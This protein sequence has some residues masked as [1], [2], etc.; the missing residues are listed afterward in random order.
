MTERPPWLQTGVRGSGSRMLK[1][2]LLMGLL[3]PSCV[4]LAGCTATQNLGG[5]LAS[6]V[7]H[8]SDAS[9]GSSGNASAGSSGNASA[10]SSGNA[11]AGSSGNASAGSSG[12]GQGDRTGVASGGSSGV[13]GSAAGTPSGSR[14][15]VSAGAGTGTPS[16]GGASGVEGGASAV[17]GGVSGGPEAGSGSGSGAG[18]SDE[19]DAT[20]DANMSEGAPGKAA[21]E[22]GGAVVG[23][24][25]STCPSGTSMDSDGRCLPSNDPYLG[26]ANP[27]FANPMANRLPGCSTPNATPAC[28]AQGNCVI[29]SCHPGFADC[30]GNPTDGCEAD[31]TSPGT[32]GSCTTACGGTQVCTPSGCASSCPLGLTSCNG[33]CADLSSS[34]LH[35]GGCG[36][37]CPP[38]DSFG[39]PSCQGGECGLVCEP[40]YTNCD[41]IC[42]DTHRDP[43]ACGSCTACPPIQN[44]I[45]TCSSGACASQCPFGWTD[46]GTACAV[47][48]ADPSNCG[49][50]GFACP[51]GNACQ[52]GQ[53]APVSSLMLATASAPEGITVDGNNV[54]FT[55]PGNGTV[56]A[57]SMDG[58]AVTTLATNQQKPRRLVGD[59]TYLYWSN[60]LG[61]E[62]MR[63]LE[64]GAGT[65]SVLTAASEPLGIA[66]DATNVYWIDAGTGLVKAVAKGGGSS[67]TLIGANG[68]QPSGELILASGAL[69][70]DEM[71]NIPIGFRLPSGPFV[72]LSTMQ[73]D[74]QAYDFSAGGSYLYWASFGEYAWYNL[75]NG[76][77][78]LSYVAAVAS[79][80]SDP[81][82]G[83]DSCGAYTW[84][85]VSQNQAE[86]PGVWMLA[87]TSD[88]PYATLAPVAIGVSADGTPRLATGGAYVFWANPGGSAGSVAG[89]YRALKPQ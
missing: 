86:I 9:A 63:T 38:G 14:A 74:V 22:A 36:G 29:A 61:G 45:L 50:C 15:G 54:F 26:C 67:V 53:C 56:N 32:C 85:E 17:E 41:G 23:T 52:A 8:A 89:V 16:E 24:L 49:A 64:S 69:Y 60:Y 47:L 57:V 35:C 31:L 42:F 19:G 21:A 73:E 83:A 4:A 20:A 5:D 81:T 39:A 27:T 37:I 77:L 6:T 44:K 62:I 7:G 46:C 87:H 30:D 3:L 88:T 65:P 33:S 82:L 59:G 76:A 12:D 11:S 58:G 40:G 66:V 18:A 80:Q 55:D 43:G 70:Y 34:V 71:A 72:T 2:K 13:S 79:G 25:C 84:N 68:G 78:G 48:S 10:G 1:A 51:S 75:A 28:D